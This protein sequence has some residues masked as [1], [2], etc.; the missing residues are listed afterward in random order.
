MEPSQIRKTGLMVAI[1]IVL[2]GAIHVAVKADRFARIGAGYKAKVMCSE[3]FVAARAGDDVLAMEFNDIDDALALIDVRVDDRSK[4]V[5]ANGPLGFG[6]AS[7][8]YRDGVGC[9]LVNG[10]RVSPLEPIPSIDAHNTEPFPKLGDPLPSYSIDHG[11]IDKALTD[12]FADDT[13]DHRAFL[14]MVDGKLVAERYDEGF[15]AQTP[16]LS[17]SMAKSVMSTLIGAAVQDELLDV[18][19]PVEPSEWNDA[20]RKKITWHH[21][22]Q[23]QSGLAFEETYVS[24]RSDVSRMLFEA[25]D[26]TAIPLSQ[27]AEYPPGEHWSYS[28]GTTNLLSRFLKETLEAAD[29][30][31]HNYLFERLLHP[32]GASSMVAEPDPAGIYLMSSFIYGT[33]R[34]WL[35]FGQLY[36]DDGVWRGERILAPGWR[37]YVA[38]AAEHSDGQYGAQ[39]WLN[40][41][42]ADERARFFPGL[43]ED[44]YFMAGRDGQYVVMVPDKNIVLIRFG[45]ARKREGMESAGPVFAALYDAV[46]YNPSE[47][48]ED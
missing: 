13:A 30:D 19:S 7:A 12:A 1:F 23:M 2:A 33:G 21:L 4:T 43:P 38:Q 37:D 40:L 34:D 48:D 45:L 42:G 3:V 29:I 16:F 36:L 18:S 17:W 5:R 35:R 10:G 15:N 14:L 6:R 26:A 24:P 22:L 39:F 27:P 9:T 8:I 28:S 20:R 46:R 32:L 31:Y 11:A 47:A 25:R 41:D 44:V